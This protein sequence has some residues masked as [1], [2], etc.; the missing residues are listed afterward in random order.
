MLY[1]MVGFYLSVAA[2]NSFYV[3]LGSPPL[4]GWVASGG[5]PC[6]GGP[7]PWQGVY[8]E[9]GASSISSMY[10]HFLEVK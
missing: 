4:P 8:C 6:G 5:D 9:D 3:S 7:I 1:L 2:I 10:G